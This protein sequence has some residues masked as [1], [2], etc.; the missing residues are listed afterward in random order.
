MTLQKDHPLS[1]A[2]TTFRHIHSYRNGYDFSVIKTATAMKTV[3]VYFAMSHTPSSDME[4]HCDTQLGDSDAM[5][6]QI[7]ECALLPSID[8]L[9]L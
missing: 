4:V 8:K 7:K 3:T 2:R 5:Q 1:H 6:T 9:S